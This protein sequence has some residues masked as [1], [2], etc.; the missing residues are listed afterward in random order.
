MIT[1][2]EEKTKDLLRNACRYLKAEH[3]RTV[4]EGPR[5]ILTAALKCVGTDLTVDLKA[6]HIKSRVE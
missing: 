6:T 4:S 2:N 3:G 5:R 1:L